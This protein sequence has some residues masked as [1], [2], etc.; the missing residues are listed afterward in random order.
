M[1][2]SKFIIIAL[3]AIAS[4]HT[5]ALEET[6]AIETTIDFEDDVFKNNSSLSSFTYKNITFSAIE[7]TEGT[8][9][10]KFTNI[11]PINSPDVSGYFLETGSNNFAGLTFS[12]ANNNVSDFSFNFGGNNVNWTLEGFDE[13]GTLLDSLAISSSPY[14]NNSDFFGISSETANI[15]YARLL[16]EEK[17]FGILDD[18]VYIDNITYTEVTPVPEPSTYA[19]MLGGLGI[20]GFMACRRRKATS[21]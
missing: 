19:L 15:S 2:H 18:A 1:I 11:N 9:A 16:S 10:F 3:L 6:M 13:S 21:A 5:Y 14:G 20:V 7:R 4:S 8:S 17:I 12:F